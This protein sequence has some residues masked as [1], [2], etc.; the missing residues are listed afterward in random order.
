MIIDDIK[1][2]LY[3]IEHTEKLVA[4][5]GFTYNEAG[6]SYNEAGMT[7]GGLYGN[8]G[9]GPTLKEVYDYQVS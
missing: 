2:F 4:N 3:T 7:Y 1:P 5:Q 9:Q 6:K 8:E